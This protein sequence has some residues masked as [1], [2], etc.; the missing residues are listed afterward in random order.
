MRKCESFSPEF[1]SQLTELFAR[2]LGMTDPGYTEQRNAIMREDIEKGRIFIAT[3]L[4]RL[5]GYSVCYAVETRD[6]VQARWQQD[7]DYSQSPQHL[8]YLKNFY[9]KKAARMSTPEHT[10]QSVVELFQHDFRSIAPTDFVLSGVVVVEDRRHEG[11]GTA[12]VQQCIDEARDHHAAAIF[13][14]CWL[15]SYG[16]E[17]F[18][19][20]HAFEPILHWGPTY[21]DGNAELIVA[22]H[23]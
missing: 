9:E 7:L 11:I 20:T 4:G 1:E 16:E 23:L 22:K 6:D 8:D 14:N 2:T 15:G 17:L 18:V 13:A 3:E 12:L 10:V 21:G 19:D 5:L